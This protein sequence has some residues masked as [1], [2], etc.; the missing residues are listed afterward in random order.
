MVPERLWTAFRFVPWDIVRF[1]VRLCRCFLLG[2]LDA[3]G[4]LGFLSQGPERLWAVL[5]QKLADAGRL[6]EPVS[7]RTRCP[8]KRRYEATWLPSV[9]TNATTGQTMPVPPFIP[10]PMNITHG[11]Y[12]ESRRSAVAVDIPGVSWRRSCLACCSRVGCLGFGR[13]LGG[14]NGLVTAGCILLWLF[15]LAVVAS[16][17]SSVAR[18][19]YSTRTVCRRPTVAVDAMTNSGER[20]IRP[21]PR[22]Y[23]PTDEATKSLVDAP[24]VVDHQTS[25]PGAWLHGPQE[26]STLE[27][28]EE[29]VLDTMPWTLFRSCTQMGNKIWAHVSGLTCISAASDPLNRGSNDVVTL[30][31]ES[32]DGFPVCQGLGLSAFDL[33]AATAVLIE[34]E[35]LG[36]APDRLPSECGPSHE[37]TTGMHDRRGPP[38]MGG[39]A[40]R[41]LDPAR[42]TMP[43]VVRGDKIGLT[44]ASVASSNTA[45]MSHGGESASED[46]SDEGL[47][48]VGSRP[49]LE[50]KDAYRVLGRQQ[51]G[52]LSDTGCPFSPRRARSA[53]YLR[54]KRDTFNDDDEGTGDDFYWTEQ[55]D[56]RLSGERDSCPALGWSGPREDESDNWRARSQVFAAREETSDAVDSSSTKLRR[57]SSPPVNVNA[58]LSHRAGRY[59]YA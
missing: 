56:A 30:G 10:Q 34:T 35:Q 41:D 9:S 20:L 47:F 3:H 24:E 55:V 5:G 37:S 23:L 25:M 26:Q 51:D 43:D 36:V 7:H 45:D 33:D 13:V 42:M 15:T 8:P 57:Y 39:V 49:P 22:D 12:D 28:L 29:S 18:A 48:G 16:R 54:N 32:E 4:E 31:R 17:S 59:V 53:G 40:I 14:Y 52:A 11:L 1:H 21:L 6:H 44:L 19:P 50:R 46:V 2:F 38:A 27:T 58:S